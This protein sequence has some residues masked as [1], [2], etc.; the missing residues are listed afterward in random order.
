MITAEQY[1]DNKAAYEA[2][3]L[4]DRADAL[5]QRVARQSPPERALMLEILATEGIGRGVIETYAKTGELSE[6]H[7]AALM[8]WAQGK[9]AQGPQGWHRADRS[10][11]FEAGAMQH[12]PAQPVAAHTP[13]ASRGLTVAE[14][15]TGKG[16]EL[17]GA[18]QQAMAEY[19]RRQAEQ[20]EAQKAKKPAIPL[21]GLA[22]RK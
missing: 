15:G 14:D 16:T 8:A 7:E 13:G 18:D 10:A 6:A 9:Y 19:K 3:R 17:P 21:L 11:P 22:W 1:R 4:A 2:Q 5:R 20:L 12:P